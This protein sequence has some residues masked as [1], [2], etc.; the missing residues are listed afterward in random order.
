MINLGNIK[1]IKTY[2]FCLG[3]CISLTIIL[4]SSSHVVS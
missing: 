3:Q 4:L 2:L 1:N